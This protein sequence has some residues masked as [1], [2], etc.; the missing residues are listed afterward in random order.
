VFIP[1]G[2]GMT[3][4]LV[5]A[6]ANHKGGSAKTAWTL[7]LGEATVARGL[8]VGLIDLDPNCTQTETLEPPDLDVA[9]SK[10]LLRNDR[11]GAGQ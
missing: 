10:D 6:V 4:P 5:L 1:E 3:V 2:Y 9:G 7:A 8:S 11:E